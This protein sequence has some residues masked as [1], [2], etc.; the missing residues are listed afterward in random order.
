MIYSKNYNKF[1][2]NNIFENIFYLIR[3]TFNLKNLYNK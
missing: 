3:Y 2:I 1:K